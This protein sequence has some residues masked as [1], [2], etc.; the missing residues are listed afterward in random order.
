VGPRTG[1][2]YPADSRA[3]A[4]T[5]ITVKIK[6][7][8]S[9]ATRAAL[10]DITLIFY[11][12][13]LSGSNRAEAVVDRSMC[14][15]AETSLKVVP[16]DK[17]CFKA[18]G[19]PPSIRRKTRRSLSSPMRLET[20][21]LDIPPMRRAFPP[22]HRRQSAAIRRSGWLSDP[23]RNRALGAALERLRGPVCTRLPGASV[24]G[25]LRRSLAR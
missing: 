17:D 18:P 13:H 19:A 8:I 7:C 10:T 2:A 15:D 11:V 6:C 5:H 20:A 25:S 21:L 4:F 3:R 16:G 14:D 12:S 22:G 9:P 23:W 24:I 1:P